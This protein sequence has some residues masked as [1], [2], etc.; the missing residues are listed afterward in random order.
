ML[1]QLGQLQKLDIN[2]L[3]E[4]IREEWKNFEVSDI[5]DHVVRLSVTQKEFHWHS[6]TNSDEFFFVIDGEL[7]I[8]LEDRTERLSSG[9][10]MT[11]PK[12]VKHRTRA[13][14]RTIVL[15]FESKDNDVQGDG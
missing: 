9:Q 13:N 14:R 12:T 3:T 7:F 5:N 6:H 10:M 8:D 15:C 11:I 2:N 1:G 4:D